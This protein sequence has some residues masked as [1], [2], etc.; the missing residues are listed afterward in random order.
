MDAP[1]PPP[2]PVHPPAPAESAVLTTWPRSAQLTT[3]ALLGAL[4]V[5]ITVHFLQASRWGTRPADLQRRTLEYRVDLNESSHAELMQ[6]PGVGESLAKRIEAH[7]P[8]GRVEDLVAVQG[9]GPALLERLRPW[10][11][12]RPARS[13]TNDNSATRSHPVGA[14]SKGRKEASLTQPIDINRATA[15]ELQRLPGIGPKLSQRIVEEREKNRFQ[16]VE[17]LRRV[18]GIGPRVFERL[19]PYITVGWPTQQAMPSEKSTNI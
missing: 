16:S 8:Y 7:R 13:D 12:V 15:E 6:L 9:I 19:R 4:A 11:G 3:A 2:P 18:S 14:T 1:L 5:L 10:V 17:D